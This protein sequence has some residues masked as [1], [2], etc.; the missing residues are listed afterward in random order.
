MHLFLGS[1]VV[2]RAPVKGKVVGSNPTRGAMR[3][4]TQFMLKQYAKMSGDK[5]VRI[6]MQW[7]KLVR[8]VNKIGLAQTKVKTNDRN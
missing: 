1:S 4:V 7:S 8:D 5:K 3:K 2:E 6:A